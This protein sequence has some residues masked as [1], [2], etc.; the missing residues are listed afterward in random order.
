MYITG[1]SLKANL[2]LLNVGR[3]LARLMNTVN[4]LCGSPFRVTKDMYITGVS[5][6][7]N[8]QLP[9]RRHKKTR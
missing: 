2:Q 4:V 1:V 3:G 9:N 5:L 6:Q 7:A 8:L